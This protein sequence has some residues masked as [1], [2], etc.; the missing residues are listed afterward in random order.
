MPQV[1]NLRLYNLRHNHGYTEQH[2]V[3]FKELVVLPYHTSLHFT[4][5]SS[6]IGR[7]NMT[8]SCR[9]GLCMHEDITIFDLSC[10]DTKI[11]VITLIAL[12]LKSHFEYVFG[13]LDQRIRE[14][15]G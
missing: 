1:T 7:L 3:C 10:I 5:D 2:T 4:A 6:Q 8:R 9:Q 12:I 11:Y 14:L 13:K 15:R